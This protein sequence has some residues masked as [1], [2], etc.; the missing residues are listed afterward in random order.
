MAEKNDEQ[1]KDAKLESDLEAKPKLL[2]FTRDKTGSVT[3]SA[4]IVALERQLKALN[5]V[6]DEVDTL[7]RSVEQSKFENGDITRN[8]GHFAPALVVSG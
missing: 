4:N 8:M 3:A 1:S 6:V 2:V 5:T 7:R